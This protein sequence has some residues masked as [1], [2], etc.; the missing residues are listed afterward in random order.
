[1]KLSFLA[2][3]Y[4]WFPFG[5]FVPFAARFRFY[6]ARVGFAA[7]MSVI[8]FV[9]LSSLLLLFIA[10]CCSL[11]IFN[12]SWCQP[13]FIGPELVRM[14]EN[15]NEQC[16]LLLFVARCGFWCVFPFALRCFLLLFVVPSRFFY[17]KNQNRQMPLVA[18]FG[19]LLLFLVFCRSFHLNTT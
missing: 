11:W 15:G 2:V 7:P 6:I 14:N 18:R 17:L 8:L 4:A 9:A 19:L 13:P 1:M 16:S 3:S 5:L 10:R 12:C